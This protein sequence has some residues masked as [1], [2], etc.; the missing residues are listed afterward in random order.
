MTNPY[1]KFFLTISVSVCLTLVA[2]TQIKKNDI[3]INFG[4][5]SGYGYPSG[6]G[7][8]DTEN[9]GIPTLNLNGE[10]SLSKYFSAGLY[11]AYTYSYF[12][13]DPLTGSGYK[14][15]WKGWDI[16]I[17]STIHVSHF[18]IK[19]NN[20][21]LYLTAFSGYSTFALVVDKNNIYRDSINYK[22]DDFSIG[23]ILGFR[24]LITRQFGF[25]VESGISRKFFVG[26]GLSFAFHSKK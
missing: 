11:S 7:R 4:A 22:V 15:V 9:S 3:L 8:I 17:K 13:Y 16:G 19:D 1:L 14:N 6:L 25:Y 12:K 2:R 26:G 5:Y 18:L 10:Y 23:G 21:Y 20:A 24:Y